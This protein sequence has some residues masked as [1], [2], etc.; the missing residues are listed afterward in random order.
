MSKLARDTVVVP[1][2]KS[3][4]NRA[5]LIAAL[6]SG[7]STIEGGLSSEDTEV[8]IRAL[9][10]FGAGC[11]HGRGNVLRVEGTGGRLQAPGQSISVRASGT[12]LRFLTAVATLAQGSVTVT[13]DKRLRERPMA[14]LI[15]ALRRLGVDVEALGERGRPPIRVAGSGFPGGRTRLSGRVSSQ[16]VSALLMVGPFGR[17]DLRLTLRQDPVSAPYIALTIDL[18]NAFGADARSVGSR[19]FAVRAGSLYRGRHLRVEG[20]ASSASYYFALAAMLGGSITV[21][22][23]DRSSRQGDIV[24]LDLLRRMGAEVSPAP[25]GTR[26]TATRLSGIEADMVDAPD[27]VPS[28]AVTAL[29]AEGR[30]VIK[31]VASLRH[32]ESDRL[33][34]LATELTRA[35]ARVE[36]LPDGL[37]IEPGPAREAVIETYDDHRIAMSFGI[38]GLVRG[39]IAIADPAVVRKSYPGFWGDLA[40]VT[41]RDE[42]SAGRVAPEAWSR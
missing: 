12:A 18:M 2:S 39:Q 33:R 7:D 4:T 35:G 27:L 17:A 13:G 28:L 36:E 30:T 22:N 23:V 10:A 41:G 14:D 31:N 1:G 29:C 20:D 42:L 8:M 5:L 16:F 24:F 37:C 40:L 15:I 34:A 21:A 6:A 19:A 9:A 32:K 26:V 25:L 38:L 11:S 3:V